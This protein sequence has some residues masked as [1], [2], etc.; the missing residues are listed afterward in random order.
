MSHSLPLHPYFLL[1]GWVYIHAVAYF[2]SDR[3]VYGISFEVLPSVFII[4]G[5][6]I[7]IFLFSGADRI[8]PSLV[9]FVVSLKAVVDRA[10]AVTHSLKTLVGNPTIIHINIRKTASPSFSR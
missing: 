3:L 6:V 5:C 2:V 1:R 9:I 4:I 7:Q 8:P 10:G